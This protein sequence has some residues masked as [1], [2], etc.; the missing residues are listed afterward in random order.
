MIIVTGSSRGIGNF[1]F[2]HFSKIGEK[3]IGTYFKTSPPKDSSD[4]LHNV[5]VSDPDSVRNFIETIKPELENIVLI[6]CAGTNYNCFAH[7]AEVEKW[8]NVINTNLLGSFLMI[9]GLL[10]VMREQN[11]GRIINLSS[12]LS[13]MGVAGTSAYSTSKS[14]LFGLMKSLVKENGN[15]GI[16]INNIDLGY[17]SIGMI[18]QVP[19]E[20]QKV[21]VDQIPMKRFG[22]PSEIL[23]TIDY[24]VKTPYL[25][26]ASL[27]LNGGLH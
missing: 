22:D 7:K 26:G 27:D 10:P 8:A 2:N 16:T 11:F 5:N 18:E 4:K 6:N 17:F 1:L 14:G 13:K 24:I 19:E 9:Q 21:M 15:K 25:N 12:V 3:V 20:I 23:N